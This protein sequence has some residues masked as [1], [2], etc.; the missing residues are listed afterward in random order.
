[1]KDGSHDPALANAYHLVTCQRFT[2]KN[3]R[4]QYGADPVLAD[5]CACSLENIGFVNG[6][7]WPCL[8]AKIIGDHRFADGEFVAIFDA[9][10]VPEPNFLTRL[11]GYFRDEKMGVVQTPHTFFKYGRFCKL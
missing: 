5:I 9:D 3:R 7:L 1:M 8:P 4:A 10:H 6:I 2:D 11:M